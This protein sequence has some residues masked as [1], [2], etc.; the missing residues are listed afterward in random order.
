MEY[1]LKTTKG[2]AG[3]FHEGVMVEELDGNNHGVEDVDNLHDDLPKGN[4]DDNGVDILGEEE[5]VALLEECTDNGN[6][7]GFM[8]AKGR[9]VKYS[10]FPHLTRQTLP[11]K[12]KAC[13]PRTT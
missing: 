4:E 9:V 8:I 7:S 13:P 1:W 3:G 5:T 12:L 6:H 11:A 2:G 10:D